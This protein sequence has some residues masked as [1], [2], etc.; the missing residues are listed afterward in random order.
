MDTQPLDLLRE[1]LDHELVDA[2]GVSCGMVDDL[3]FADTPSGPAPVALFAGPGA[4]GPRL[5]ALAALAARW[6]FGA[7]RVRVPWDA[8]D[9]IGET[10][11]LKHSAGALGLGAVD[12]RTERWLRRWLRA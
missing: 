3:E 4:W 5:P 10:V 2:N 6:L 1:V 8:V 12:R 7:R 9:D 11:R